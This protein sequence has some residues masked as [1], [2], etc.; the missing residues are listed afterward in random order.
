MKNEKEFGSNDVFDEITELIRKDT[1]RIIVP[2]NLEP[3][4]IA[5][6][7]K[8]RSGTANGAKGGLRKRNIAVASRAAALLAACAALAA[9]V[10]IYG[11]VNKETA[12]LD[13]QIEY[14]DVSGH[15]SYDD[16][17]DIYSRIYLNSTASLS[18]SDDISAEDFAEELS[19]ADTVKS[20]DGAIY[21]TG[22]GRIVKASADGIAVCADIGGKL[23]LEMYIDNNKLI[24]VSENAEPMNSPDVPADGGN[25]AAA[26]N[27]SSSSEADKY[28]TADIYDISDGFCFLESFSQSGGYISS[29]VFGGNLSIVTDYA[30]SEL[31]NKNGEDLG[32]FVP[33][34]ELNGKRIYAAAEDIYV[35]ED[36]ESADYTVVS[37]YNLEGG[38][39]S[40]KAVL[41]S[42]GKVFCPSDTLY[43][44][45]AGNKNAPKPYTAIS[46][47]SLD[48]TIEYISGGSVEGSVLLSSLDE[49]DGTLRAAAVNTM[50][51]GTICTDIYVLDSKLHVIN[52]AGQLL[53]GEK[54]RKVS[55]AE[56]YASLYTEK[57][58]PPDLVLDLSEYPPE[59]ASDMMASDSIVYGK[60]DSDFVL[61]SGIIKE[62][63]ENGQEE[64]FLKLSMFSAS[65]GAEFDSV[66][67]AS[68][69]K[70]YSDAALRRKSILMD[71]SLGI[72]GVPVSVTDDS[73][74]RS[75]YYLYRFDSADGFNEIGR[76]EFLGGDRSGNFRTA[77]VSSDTIYI[78]SDARVVTADISDMKIKKV[79][80]ID[81]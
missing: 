58:S 15:D 69:A 16:L 47:F 79:W 14:E 60:Y 80:T 70:L 25:L 37:S 31:E 30:A 77:Y 34:Y 64:Y 6:M 33:Y 21:F 38:A 23:P 67:V 62:T 65:S 12:L 13:S 2:E 51:D 41:G 20:A 59:V 50:D 28:V 11:S 10:G 40:V 75:A 18:V 7:L 61:G 1:D 3:D 35:F 24:L 8:T 19:D 46:S 22:N 39:V 54:V 36:A 4:N 57:D 27:G 81:N 26:D 32:S 55:F 52:S 43:I 78:I 29:R 56:R 66:R 5:M 49:K 73:G 53:P 68:G 72:I 42:S 71:S 17:Y 63:D 74:V 48:G 9:G 76:V 44:I 45:S